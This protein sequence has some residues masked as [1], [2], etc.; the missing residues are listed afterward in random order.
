MGFRC[1]IANCG[2]QVIQV[3]LQKS[4]NEF[5][6]H[7]ARDWKPGLPC[8]FPKDRPSG[9]SPRQSLPKTR[10]SLAKTVDYCCSRNL[11]ICLPKEGLSFRATYTLPRLS[12]SAC[13]NLNYILE[14]Y[15]GLRTASQ[16]DF[17]SKRRPTIPS[18]P[19]RPLHRLA[20]RRT[21]LVLLG[22][23]LPANNSP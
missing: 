17:I 1:Q 8:L 16:T 6:G 2:S 21:R 19:P 4:T 14:R 10:S 23:S 15:L 20:L 12:L 22:Y 3:L 9:R 13:G 11:V 7:R 18:E 5:V